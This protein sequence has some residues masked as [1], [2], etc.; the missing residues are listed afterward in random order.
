M[1]PLRIVLAG[2]ESAGRQVLEQVA[3]TDH[4]LVAVLTADADGTIGR[5]GG[6][7][8]ASVLPAEA[9]KQSSF[10]TWLRDERVDVLLNVH[11]LYIIA[12]EVLE[13]PRLGAYN[14]HPGPLPEYSGLNCV[15]WAI[16]EGATEYGVTL[17]QMV[18]KIDAGEIVAMR[19]FP[20]EPDDTPFTLATRCIREGVPLV[21]E[22]VDALAGDPTGLETTPQDLGKRRYYGGGVPREG[23]ID[24]RQPAAEVCRFVRAFDYF[25]F[26]SPWGR[27]KLRADGRLVEVKQA[28]QTGEACTEPPGTLAG[29]DGDGA[30]RV[31]ASDEWVVVT[32]ADADADTGLA[33]PDGLVIDS[34]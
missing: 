16:L 12:A 18:P 3:R 10:A 8:D 14:L 23:V 32:F 17:H 6:R 9:V 30:R 1:E 28:S 26:E 24:W 34:D 33:L 19:R 25:R 20:V 21:V 31:A 4:E 13:A 29:T 7:L 2:E 27:P 5:L 11:S 15:S 22:L